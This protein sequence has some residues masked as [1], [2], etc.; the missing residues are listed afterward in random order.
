MATLKFT[1]VETA[2]FIDLFQTQQYLW[3]VTITNHH[4]KDV[5]QAAMRVILAKMMEYHEKEMSG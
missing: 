3:N 5:R 1:D 2:S 4:R